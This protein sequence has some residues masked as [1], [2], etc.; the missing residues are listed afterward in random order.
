VPVAACAAQTTGGQETV[1]GFVA[2][3]IVIIG[4]VH[5]YLWKRLV[6]DPMRPGK[7]RRLGGV[8]ALLLAVLVPA[9]LIGTRSGNVEWLA[10]PGYV[11]LGLM[12]Y[13][14]T[15]LI[16]VEVP[17]LAISLWLRWAD[18]AETSRR[19]TTKNSQVEAPT[20]AD[21]SATPGIERR[22]LLARGGAIFAGLTATGITGYGIRTALG[23]PQLDRVQI[24]LAKLP[25]S[26]DGTRFAVVS[27]IHLGPL[28]GSHHVGRIVDMINSLDANVVCIVGDLV[29]GTVAELGGFAAPLANIKSK[30]GA[31]FVTG[32]H[33]YYSG[34]QPWIDEVA[35][36]GV[37]PLR[38]ER[39]ELGALDLAGVNDLGGV[40]YGDGP[41]FAKALGNRDPSRPVILLAHQPVV[42][43]DAAKFGVDLQ[44]SGHTHGGQMVPF[45]LL[46]KLQQP[47]VSGYGEVD[48]V[49]VYVTNGAGFWGPPVRVGAPP[50]VTLV[51]LRTP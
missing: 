39:L 44:L 47:I 25:R 5:L 45:N 22:L 41:D 35:R 3:I 21:E 17:R 14:L 30:Q 15:I 49:P 28:T 20:D 51:E 6:R 31:Y 29:D 26:L 36:L 50:Q 7:W 32:N 16:I 37:R 43:R 19:G 38:N 24:P 42:A 8:V 34:F 13:L 12:F 10:W 27:D 48:G 9:T 46:I 1:F 11:W 4:L 40:Q 2:L 18:N 33:E 23:P